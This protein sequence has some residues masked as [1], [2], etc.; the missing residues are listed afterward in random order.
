[1]S[2]TL[3]TKKIIII[4]T[5]IIHKFQLARDESANNLRQFTLL[6]LYTLGRPAKSTGLPSSLLVYPVDYW[7]C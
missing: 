6:Q 4:G 5:M 7:F 3:T 2:D 1:M